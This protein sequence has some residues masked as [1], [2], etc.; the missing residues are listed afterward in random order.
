MVIATVLYNLS[1]DIGKVLE[2]SNLHT[3][4]SLVPINEVPFPAIIVDL[5][6]EVDP[7]GYISTSKD[8]GHEDGFP[9]EGNCWL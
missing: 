2:V 6:G 7:V 4:I 5:G 8:I 9:K 3:D 1:G